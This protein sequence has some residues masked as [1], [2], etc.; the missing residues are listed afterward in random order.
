MSGRKS[1]IA[2]VAL[3]SL[4][5]AGAEIERDDPGARHDAMVEWRGERV[6]S[7]LEAAARER[8]RYD[9]GAPRRAMFAAVQGSTFVNLGPTSAD[10]EFNG[11]QY[12]EI[13][14]G[15]ARQVVPHPWNKDILYLSTATGGVW[16]SY[17]AG[18]GWEPITDALGTT[19]IGALAMD[20]SNPDILYV[21]FGDPFDV[22]QPGLVK[23]SDGGATWSA[24]VSLVTA[25]DQARTA[26]IT[27]DIKV[28]PRNSAVV[29]AS[30][31]LG[32]FRSVDAGATWHQVALGTPNPSETLFFVWSLAWVGDDPGTGEGTWLATG[33]VADPAL[34]T[35]TRKNVG[36]FTLWR[37]T[38]D[39]ATWTWNGG[40]LPGGDAQTASIGRG[41]LAVA[42][43]TLVDPSTA[44]V[45]L[46][47][48][49]VRGDATYELFRSDDAGLSFVGSGFS[50]NGAPTNPNPNQPDLDLLHNQAWYN[51]AIAV[52]PRNADNVMVGGD[53]SVA[54]SLDAGATWTLV[55]NWLPVPQGISLPYIHADLHS[56]AFGADGT[57]Y[58]G[59][60]GGIGA[61]VGASG[62]SSTRNTG[63]V[64]HQAY[65]VACAPESWPAELQG[66]VVGG[67]QDNG[68]RLRV[69]DGTT[70]NEVLGGDGISVVVSGGAHQT[71]N[72]AVPDA[73]VSST[74]TRIFRSADGGAT[75]QRFTN[76]FAS[77]DQLPFFVRIAR[78]TAAADGQTFVTYTDTPAKVYTSAGGSPWFN[79]SG[80]LRWPDGSTTKG[81]ITPA[82]QVI[83]LRSVATDSAQ[84][85][86]Y[87]VVSNKFAY[88]TINGG[89][90]WWVSTQPAPPGT[91]AGTGIYQ[92]SS[93]AF[94]PRDLNGLT[95]Y[96]ASNAMRLANADGT[97]FPPLPQSF[98]HLYKTIDAG[99]TW[100]S[101]GTQDVNSGG[102]PF[103]PVQVIAVDPG[104][105]NTLYAGTDLGLYRSSDGGANWTRM[106]AGSLPLVEVDGLCISPGSGRL[107]VATYGRGFWQIGTSGTDPAGVRGDGDTNFDQRIDGLDLIDLADALGTTQA[108][109]LYRWKAD[110]VGSVNAIDSSDL[111]AL[112]GKFGGTP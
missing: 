57:V 16:K 39:G 30:T 6:F 49:T 102:L 38:D 59:S 62:F 36:K 27:T 92:L 31:D 17:D 56:L 66:F 63:L 23:S 85:G 88:V 60:D 78:D 76:G 7:V 97:V 69:G 20:P 68:T 112:L 52:D 47:T 90:N 40:A 94:D 87:G 41:T 53:L 86:I 61:S 14:S 105:P 10:S 48:A 67:L 96:V 35:S 71:V 93:I 44:R 84:S 82:G 22:A 5:A 80:Q 42:A 72:G 29:L 64:T 95:Y 107:T 15:R 89:A 103:V 79:I 91:P 74:P 24:P 9:I 3:A 26:V 19:A 33:E 111:T 13:D 50:S 18:A 51:Q 99:E 11:G 104:D 83:Q 98:G 21:G 100:T 55:S 32:L 4:A 109:P 73:I 43:S 45:F 110:L 108:S 70:F 81:F 28:D 77:G 58:A 2:L 46:L 25:G 1:L 34:P 12:F 106:G 8:D 75:W 54:Q 65:S 101:L 37:S